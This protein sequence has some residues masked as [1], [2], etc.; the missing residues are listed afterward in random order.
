MSKGNNYFRPIVGREGTVERG[1][2]KQ[3]H[4]AQ[5]SHYLLVHMLPGGRQG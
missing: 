4:R 2:R 5:W 3:T 1:I